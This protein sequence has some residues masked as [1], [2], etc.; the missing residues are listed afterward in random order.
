[1]PFADLSIT[2]ADSPDPV[3]VGSELTYSV[4]VSN[5]GPSTVTNV[6]VMDTLPGSVTFVSA[7][8]TQGTCNEAAGI[9]ACDLGTLG[10][11]DVVAIDI[12]VI[13]TSSGS[14]SNTV[15]V[16]GDGHDP[17]PENN[18]ASVDSAVTLGADLSISKADLPDPVFVGAL[19]IYQVTVTNSGPDSAPGVVMT[20]DLPLETAYIGDNAGCVYDGGAHTLECALGNLPPEGNALVSVMVATLAEGIITNTATVTSDQI[21][22]DLSNNTVAEDT[23]VEPS[24]DL[25]VSQSDS[26]DPVIIGSE[27]T[28]AVTFANN[29]P[30]TAEDVVLTSA[31]SDG[32]ALLSMSESQV[33]QVDCSLSGNTISCNL[34]SMAVGEQ[35]TLNV[36]VTPQTAGIVTNTATATA[37]THDPDQS[38]NTSTEESFVVDPSAACTLDLALSYAGNTLAMDFDIFSTVPTQWGVWLFAQSDFMPLWSVALPVIDPPVSLPLSFPFPQ[39]GTIAILTIMTTPTESVLCLDFDIVDTGGSEVSKLPRERIRELFKNS[40]TK[41]PRGR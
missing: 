29:G 13:P 26:P 31:F 14:I 37:S 20:D 15:S 8:S 41:L 12:V 25:S 40:K 6:T 7:N 35:L 11:L 22:P 21:D 16:T 34:E 33:A 32:A 1:M 18:S 3:L 23:L 19:L 5:G 38:N 27:L 39:M 30:S 28:Y 24:A 17:D 10:V 9:V 2:K 4:N 36:A